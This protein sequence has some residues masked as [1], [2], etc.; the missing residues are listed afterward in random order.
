[1]KQLYILALSIITTTLAYAQKT[2]DNF[3]L[4]YNV[5]NYEDIRIHNF[6]GNVVVNAKPG[7][8]FSLKVTRKLKS[9][10][11]SDLQKAKEEVYLDTTVIDGEFIVFM[12]APDKHF[13]ID[14]DGGS[15]YQGENWD[16]WSKNNIKKYGVEYEFEIEA[17]IPPHKNLYAATHHNDVKVAGIQGNTTVKSHHGNVYADTGG[18]I[19]VAKT[20]HGDVKVDHSSNSVS[21]G[22]YITHHGD[23]ETSFPQVSAMVSLKSHHGSFYTDFDYDHVAQKVNFNKD[24]KKTMYKYGGETNIKVGRGTGDFTYRTHHGDTFINKN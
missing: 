2:T 20:H 4:N 1:M 10:S 23:I 17:S 6:K 3:N 11:K 19:V 22:V 5:A 7:K 13:K 21:K 24:G 12:V 16:N 8:E 9:R 14:D 15:Y 18:E